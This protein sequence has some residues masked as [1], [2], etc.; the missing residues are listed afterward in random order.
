MPAT[1]RRVQSKRQ[2]VLPA[3]AHARAESEGLAL[4]L[5]QTEQN[6]TRRRAL[7]APPRLPDSRRAPSAS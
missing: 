4:E 5:L 3:P 7:A 2:S 1:A 6:V